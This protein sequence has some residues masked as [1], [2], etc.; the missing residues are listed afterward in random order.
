MVVGFQGPVPPPQ[1]IEDYNR[2]SPGSGDRILEDAH[3]N[4]I[5]DR[6]ITRE[7]FEH[8]KHEAWARIIIAAVFL[9]SCVSGIFLCL[10]LFEPPESLVGAG[11]FS[12]GA[13]ASVVREVM[14]GARAS[15]SSPQDDS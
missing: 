14:N 5:E 3:Q 9:F 1:I 13:I 10:K 15:R 12:L 11:L 2:I 8:A 7:A 4:T 6:K